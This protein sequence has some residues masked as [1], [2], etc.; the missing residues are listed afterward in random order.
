[1]H[2]A[3]GG[4]RREGETVVLC[5]GHGPPEEGGGLVAAG[6]CRRWL[7]LRPAVP[8]PRASFLP[9]PPFSDCFCYK[10]LKLCFMSMFSWLPG[11]FTGNTTLLIKRQVSGE[12]RE[13]PGPGVHLRVEVSMGV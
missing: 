5:L 8:R 4:R 12:W 7:S 3:A 6:A 11:F 2:G 13:L 9:C 10:R 1:M